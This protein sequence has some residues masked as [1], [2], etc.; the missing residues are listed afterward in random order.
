MKYL[1]TDIEAEEVK[2]FIEPYMSPDRHAVE[3]AT[4]E[5]N[6]MYLDS[7]DLALYWSSERGELDRFK[8]RIR[9]YTDYPDAPVFFEI[10]RRLNHVIS[11]RRARVHRNAVQTA[12]AGEAIVPGVL[13]VATDDESETLLQFRDRMEFL[14]ATP[15]VAVRYLREAYESDFEDRVRVTIDQ[16]LA[17]LPC[18]EYDPAVWTFDERWYNM[19]H[20]AAVLEIKFSDVFPDWLRL[21]VQRLHLVRD[22]IA[23]YVVCMKELGHEGV[24]VPEL[25]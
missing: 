4:Y 16:S 23:K 25:A 10:K 2:C 17:C 5:V 12:L 9:S 21:L 19:S 20:F 3:G 11:K 13:A 18:P 7:P 6:T 22:S 8:L 24:Y 1:I 15:R 14:E